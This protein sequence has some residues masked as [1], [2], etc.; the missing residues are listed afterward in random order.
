MAPTGVYI[1]GVSYVKF[2]YTIDD[3]ELF[4]N[5]TVYIR[6]MDSYVYQFTSTSAE[7]YDAAAIEEELKTIIENAEWK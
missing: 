3:G 6:A 2:S 7:A 4:T 5:N 1:D